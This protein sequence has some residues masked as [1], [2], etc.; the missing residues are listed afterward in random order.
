MSDLYKEQLDVLVKQNAEQAEE[1]ELL[2]K[3]M[4]AVNNEG[5]RLRRE[6]KRLKKHLVSAVCPNSGKAGYTDYCKWCRER[7]VLLDKA[8]QPQNHRKDFTA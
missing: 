4:T 2:D 1:I 5:V 3:A 8:A 7:D 6:N